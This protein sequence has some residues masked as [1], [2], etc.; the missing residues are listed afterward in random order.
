LTCTPN[1]FDLT[2]HGIDAGLRIIPP[3]G[4]FTARVEISVV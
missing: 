2:R 4:S 1:S 3:G